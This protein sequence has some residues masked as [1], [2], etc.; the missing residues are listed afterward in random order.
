MLKKYRVVNNEN[1]GAIELDGTT[2]QLES[3]TDDQ[4]EVLYNNKSRYVER[5]ET[6]EESTPVSK[7]TKATD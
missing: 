2:Y 5:V 3:L 4:A 7:K 1:I 6:V